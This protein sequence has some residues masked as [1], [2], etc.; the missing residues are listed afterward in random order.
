MIAGLLLSV[1]LALSAGGQQLT[2][3]G[4]AGSLPPVPL[5]HQREV[6]FPGENAWLLMWRDL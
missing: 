1:I 3:T 5:V 2:V 4:E 6:A